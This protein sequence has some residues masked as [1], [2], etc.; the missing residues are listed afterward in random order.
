VIKLNYINDAVDFQ[1]INHILVIKLQ[2]LGDSLLT[3][4]LYSVIKKQFP[5]ITID[6]LVYQ[7]ALP[8]LEG[9]PYI[10]QYFSID[11]DWKKKGKVFQLQNEYNLLKRLKT[12]PYD[13]VLNL[14]DRWRGAWLTRILKPDYSVSLPYKHRRGKFWARSFSHLYRI[15]QS[16]RHTVERNLDAI[17]R[18][19]VQPEIENKKLTFVINK[20]S[21]K[22]IG[23]LIQ[24]FPNSKKTII[25][26]H[27]TSRWMF[28]AWNTDGFAKVIKSL[29]LSGFCVV[30]ISGPAKEEIV[31]VDAI[32]EKTDGQ[33]IN[34]SGKLSLNESAALIRQADCFLGLDS[35]AMHISAAVNTP[36]VAIFGPTTDKVW[37]PWMVRH[38]VIVENYDCRPCGLKGCGDGIFSECIQDIKP[39]TVVQAVMSL[40]KK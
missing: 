34:L 29:N 32:I 14:T 37:K 10:S 16:N 13:L 21:E 39:E 15:P 26:I 1:N 24:S 25:V 35:V 9:N 38:K 30:L 7:E 2:H 33:A 11:R 5:H 23:Q 3:T 36:C 4:P 28:K 31:Y 8:M 20:C 19:G 22:K 27:P 40:V 12:N 17:R 6:V 18:L